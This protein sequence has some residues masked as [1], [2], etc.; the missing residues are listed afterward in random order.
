MTVD[1]YCVRVLH[2]C[3]ICRVCPVWL[4]RVCCLYICDMCVRAAAAAAAVVCA[5]HIH[6]SVYVRVCVCVLCVVLCFSKNPSFDGLLIT[7]CDTQQ[8][9]THAHAHIHIASHHIHI[10]RTY[11]HTSQPHIQSRH[12]IPIHIDPSMRDATRWRVTDPV[13]HA[14]RRIVPLA[15]SPSPLVWTC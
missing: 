7:N 5:E 10:T 2:A 8:Q 11:V 13:Q 12:T 15:P 4:P 1:A 14:A 9:S 6:M 3:C